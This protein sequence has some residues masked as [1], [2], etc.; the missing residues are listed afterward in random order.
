MMEGHDAIKEYEVGDEKEIIK[1]HKEVFNSE[2]DLNRWK[3]QFLYHPKG[4]G[5]ISL[6]QANNEIV[7][8][9]CMMRHH[10]NFLGREIIAGQS[11]DTMVKADQRGKRWFTKLANHNYEFAA[12]NGVQAVFGFPNRNSYPGFM[13]HL[14]WIRLF[15]LNYYYY[16]LGL[17]KYIGNRLDILLNIFLLNKFLL[18][19]K[20]FLKS[21][22]KD[23]AIITTEKIPKNLDD[24]LKEICNYEVLS[25]WKDNNYLRWRYENHPQNKYLFHMLMIGKK[26]EGLVVTRVC[27]DNVRICEVLSR[28]K[29]I[30]ITHLLVYHVMIYSVKIKAQKIEFYGFDNGFFDS[31]FQGA[32]FNKEISQYIFGGKVFNDRKLKNMFM[33]PNN[34]SISFGDIDVI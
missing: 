34:W 22:I 5:W 20:I 10:L 2:T 16:R 33:I 32:Q 12:K 24:T 8:Q 9:Y 1:L 11:C 30:L 14:D 15:N 28:T 27:N 7:G 6:A 25:I 18:R 26:I 13:K 19:Y 21:R 3:W 23:F 17:K 29:S 31:V 4:E